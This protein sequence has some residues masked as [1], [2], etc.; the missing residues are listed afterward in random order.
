[1]KKLKILLGDPRHTTVGAHSYFVP[2]GIGYI[3]SNLLK[4]FE[5]H[6]IELKICVDP[7]EIFTLLDEWKPD[8]IGISNY[9]WNSDISKFMCEYAK[10]IN[11]NTL[12]VL[13]GPEFPAGTG[14]RKIEDNDEDQTYTKCLEYLF[15]RPSVDY[16]AY[17]DGEVAFVEIVKKFIE[18]NYS[19]KSMKDKN[20]P[21][22]GC[23]SLAK[24]KNKIHVG[25]Y[26]S[27]IGMMGSVKNEGRDE[28]WSTY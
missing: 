18:N 15:E 21:M 12:C 28:T 20:E 25:Q 2:I 8:I 6:K 5:D 16:F 11:P 13:G 22:K 24:E 14:A 1:M 10:E 19:L 23:V 27:R 3:G 9:I 4:K 7:E 26:I 17:S